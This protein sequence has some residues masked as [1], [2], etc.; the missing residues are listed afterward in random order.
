MPGVDLLEINPNRL[1]LSAEGELDGVFFADC[2]AKVFTDIQGFRNAPA[3][4]RKVHT[5]DGLTVNEKPS[6]ACFGTVP[7]GVWRS[8]RCEP[9]REFKNDVRFTQCKGMG[10]SISALG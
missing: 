9:G 8:S 4:M 2:C 7:E 3:K 1:D 10:R 5:A 6:D